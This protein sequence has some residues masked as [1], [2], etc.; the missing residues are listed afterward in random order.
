M[1]LNF[2]FM[3]L[4]GMIYLPGPTVNI[5]FQKGY[6]GQKVSL[7]VDNC[8][9]FENEVLVSNPV[10]DLAGG[11]SVQAGL[12]YRDVDG[13]PISDCFI[14]YSQFVTIKIVLDGRYFE[15]KFDLRE[16]SFIGIVNAGGAPYYIQ[17]KGPFLY[18]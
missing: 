5:D 12:I 15:R 3:M 17:N 11:A 7:S 9:I 8:V 1:S 2:S 18:D 13:D 6:N 14:P 16:G 10:L 4:L